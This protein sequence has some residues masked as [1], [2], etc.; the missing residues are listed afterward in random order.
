MNSTTAVKDPPLRLARA[1]SAIFSMTRIA[2]P[3]H[4]FAV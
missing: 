2:F 4:Q 1:L 3:D